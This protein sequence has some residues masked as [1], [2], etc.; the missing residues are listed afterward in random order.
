MDFLRGNNDSYEIDIPV[1]TKKETN[2]LNEYLP[3]SNIQEFLS[4]TNKHKIP[5]PERKS[6]YSL[7]RFLPDFRETSYW[8]P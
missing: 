1:L 2:F 7:Y 5:E 4:V 8:T 6:Y 3:E